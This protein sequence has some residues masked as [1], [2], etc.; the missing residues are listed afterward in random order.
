ML[1]YC[2][3]ASRGV[4]F[5]SCLAEIPI[6]LSVLDHVDETMPGRKDDGLVGQGYLSVGKSHDWEVMDGFR[7]A[8]EMNEAR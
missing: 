4:F 2:G 8:D 5:D 7:L 3:V 1:W 6:F